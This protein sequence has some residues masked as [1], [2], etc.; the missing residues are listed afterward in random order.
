[1][2]CINEYSMMCTHFVAFPIAIKL[3]SLLGDAHLNLNKVF[4]STFATSCTANS[5]EK[6]KN[7]GYVEKVWSFEMSACNPATAVLSHSGIAHFSQGFMGNL[8]GRH[9]EI[10]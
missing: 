7:S 3:I 10:R 4:L 8:C 5:S 2:S 1:M 6:N 9:F